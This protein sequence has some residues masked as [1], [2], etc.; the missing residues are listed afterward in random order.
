[1][2]DIRA[3][4]FGAAPR[5]RFIGTLGRGGMSVVFHAED[6]ELSSEVAIKVLLARDEIAWGDTLERLKLETK[7]NWKIRHPNVARVFDLGRAGDFSYLTMEYIPGEDLARILESRGSLPAREAVPILRQI[8]LGVG[9]A[10]KLGFVHRD[11]KPSNIMVDRAGVA[12]VLDFGVARALSGRRRTG[13]GIVMGTPAFLSPEQA[14]GQ[15]VGP[16]SDVFSLGTLGYMVLTG[17]LPF[18]GPHPLA[19][20]T[21]VITDPVPEAPLERSGVPPPLV[22]ILLRCLRK[23]PAERYETANQLESALALLPL[24]HPTVRGVETLPVHPVDDDDL[25]SVFED[26]PREK[27]RQEDRPRH[28]VITEV[29][30][31]QVP[32]V[33]VADDDPVVRTLLRHHLEAAGCLV[34]EANDGIEA[35]EAT[36]SGPDLVLMDIK[37]PRMDGLDA[38]RIIKTR[39]EAAALP[40]I[41]MS[42]IRDRSRL[43]FAIQCG[44]TEFLPKPLDIP[45]LLETIER[46][47]SFRGLRLPLHASSAGAA[48]PA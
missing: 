20:A 47:L 13:P 48:G 9:A 29:L 39:P 25:L 31:V 22:E 40:I 8:A 43:A 34:F 16:S 37:M 19:I 3:D 21:A 38:T 5:Y 14:S 12:T 17:S 36:E 2:E 10:H 7:I 18:T 11:L 41:I 44:A 45:R 23:D 24:P 6:V 30:P 42:I 15:E 46:V 33:L 32:S 27:P 26:H 4:F 28:A 35:V 1:M